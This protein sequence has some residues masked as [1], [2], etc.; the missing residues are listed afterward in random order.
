MT[1][2]AP[3]KGTG[4]AVNAADRSAWRRRMGIEENDPRVLHRLRQKVIQRCQN[5]TPLGMM[6]VG[7]LR[8]FGGGDSGRSLVV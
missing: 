6:T 8:S 7:K 2:L 3:G 1:L 5:I 4:K